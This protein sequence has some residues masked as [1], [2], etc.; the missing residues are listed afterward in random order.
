M[1]P[2]LRDGLGQRFAL[3]ALAGIPLVDACVAYADD[4]NPWRLLSMLGWLTVAAAW[5]LHP[6][7]LYRPKVDEDHPIAK[8]ALMSRVQF[9]VVFGGGLLLAVLGGVGRYVSLRSMLT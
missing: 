9:A 3:A 8:Q 4:G 5:F 2:S 6:S 7:G 1:R